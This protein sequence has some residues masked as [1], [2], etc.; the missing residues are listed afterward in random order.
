MELVTQ[1]ELG[2]SCWISLIFENPVQNFPLNLESWVDVSSKGAREGLSFLPALLLHSS[3]PV[4]GLHLCLQ[5]S[6]MQQLL[7][8]AESSGGFNCT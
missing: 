5:L 6:S 3:V 1:Y 2:K 4:A 8:P 7:V